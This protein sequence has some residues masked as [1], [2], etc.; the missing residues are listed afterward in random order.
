[1]LLLFIVAVGLVAAIGAQFQPGDWYRTLAKPAW[2]PPDAVFAPVWS[3]LY[4]MMAVAGWLL[5]RRAPPGRPLLLGL[6]ALQLVLNAA[7][8][9][10]FFGRH[11]IGAALA[12]LTLLWLVLLALTLSAFPVERRAG[13]LLTPYLLWVSY[14]LAL[15]FAIWHLNG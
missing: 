6:F 1:M 8:S 3:L 15:N 12:D 4:L 10:L 14:A 7:W 5:W 11:A 2:T 9:W 13:G